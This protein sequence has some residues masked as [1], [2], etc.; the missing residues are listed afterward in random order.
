MRLAIAPIAANKRSLQSLCSMWLRLWQRRVRRA[1]RLSE[2]RA[3]RASRSP[4]AAHTSAYVSIRQQH[5]VSQHEGGCWFSLLR[6]AFC[7]GN[8]VGCCNLLIRQHTT[9]SF[10][11]IRRLLVWLTEDGFGFSLLQPSLPV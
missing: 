7:L 3:P 5:Y 6:T 10:V 2:L 8:S 4:P 9:S 1:L 11:S